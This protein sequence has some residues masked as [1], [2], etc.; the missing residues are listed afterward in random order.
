LAEV[1]VPLSAAARRS[2]RVA[3]RLLVRVRPNVAL[4]ALTGVVAVALVRPELFLLLRAR[5]V[6]WSE[7]HRVLFRPLSIE[8]FTN[9]V[10]LAVRG[11]GE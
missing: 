6:G 5:D 2:P 8:L 3:R 11:R 10:E 1:A 4:Y 7:L 9:T